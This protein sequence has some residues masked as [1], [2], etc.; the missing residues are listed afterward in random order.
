MYYLKADSEEDLFEA[1]DAAG[2]TQRVYDMDDPRNVRPA[3]LDPEDA[4]AP[5]GEYDSVPI[6][7]VDLD[8]IGTIFVPSGIMLADEEGNQ[9]PEMIPVEGYH[10]NV[11]GIT[12]E[13]AEQLPTIGKPT[14]AVRMWAGD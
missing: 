2:V 1:L 9:Y 12:A 7:G 10:A 6:A 13:Q 3:D 5:T 4:W 14:K 11:R 8:I